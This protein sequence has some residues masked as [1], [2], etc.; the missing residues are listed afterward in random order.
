MALLV[1]FT[2][3]VRQVSNIEDHT[4]RMKYFQLLKTILNF[5][6]YFKNNILSIFL[7]FGIQI[8]C[9]TGTDIGL[10]YNYVA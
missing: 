8:K 4:K 3:G 9:I 2:L 10:L 5:L 7:R 6:N 1:A